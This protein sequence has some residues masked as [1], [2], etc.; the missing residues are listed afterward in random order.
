MYWKNILHSYTSAVF[1]RRAKQGRRHRN[2]R[3]L[4]SAVML[5]RDRDGSETGCGVRYVA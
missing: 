2:R 1:G 3:Q 4:Q 5:P